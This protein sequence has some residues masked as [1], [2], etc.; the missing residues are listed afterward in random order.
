MKPLHLARKIR[1]IIRKKFVAPPLF[2]FSKQT[3]TMI[4]QY[5]TSSE[6]NCGATA[7]HLFEADCYCGIAVFHLQHSVNR[8]GSSVN[9]DARVFSYCLEDDGTTAEKYFRFK[10]FYSITVLIL[11]IDHLMSKS[12]FEYML[13]MTSLLSFNRRANEK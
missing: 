4:L 12:Q 3:A 6:E 2:T 10:Y 7:F 9:N 1:D 13:T 5:S 11:V 8:S